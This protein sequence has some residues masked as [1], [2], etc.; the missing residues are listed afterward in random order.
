MVGKLREKSHLPF[1]WND[2]TGECGDR[3]AMDIIKPVKIVRTA[4]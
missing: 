2:Q 4:L 1:G 3:I